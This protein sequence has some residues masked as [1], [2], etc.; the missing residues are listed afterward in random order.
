M[1]KH[2]LGLAL[3][4]LA[5]AACSKSRITPPRTDGGS[6]AGALATY[7]GPLEAHVVART[8]AWRTRFTPRKNQRTVLDAGLFRYEL[9]ADG[10]ATRLG[11]RPRTFSYQRNA[12]LSGRRRLRGG[13]RLAR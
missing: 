11:E 1:G 10:T 8:L 6:D 13:V 3:V 2:A 4:V 5:T 12:D 9:M 7:A